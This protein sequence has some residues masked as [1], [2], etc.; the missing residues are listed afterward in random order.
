LEKKVF[1]M[2]ALSCGVD[3]GSTNVKVTFVDE[4]GHAVWT[5]AVPTPRVSDDGGV[6]TDA[7]GLV[8]MIEEMIVTGWRLHGRS[9][10]LRAIAAA[11]VGEDGVGVRADLTPTGLA[12][13]WFD[14]RAATQAND[15]QRTSR[16]AAQAGLAI[17]YSRTAA[18]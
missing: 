9:L 17:D 2:S 18:I 11:G 15:L 12:L 14:E 7:L 4:C 5:K 16:Y 1:A 13:P 3:I 6:A 10:P 8:A